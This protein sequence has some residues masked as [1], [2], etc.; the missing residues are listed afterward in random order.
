MEQELLETLDRA[1]K[2]SSEGE[3]QLGLVCLG[4]HDPIPQSCSDIQAAKLAA[5]LIRAGKIDEGWN[6]LQRD[7]TQ[8]SP[9]AAGLAGAMGLALGIPDWAEPSLVVP[10]KPH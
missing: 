1:W 5:I 4:S 8:A 6:Y 3:E 9:I 7:W 10:A 2:L